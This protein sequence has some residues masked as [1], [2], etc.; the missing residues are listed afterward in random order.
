MRWLLLS[1][2]AVGLTVQHVHMCVW[3]QLVS[4]GMKICA[5][6]VSH[7][8]PPDKSHKET[9]RVLQNKLQSRLG[10]NVVIFL[11]NVSIALSDKL[12]NVKSYGMCAEVKLRYLCMD[13]S[14][15]YYVPIIYVGCDS[16]WG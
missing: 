10:L 11:D 1:L 14:I 9:Q 8:Q 13:I 6:L 4:L 15:V 3:S 12:S 7:G 2:I 16:F 5:G